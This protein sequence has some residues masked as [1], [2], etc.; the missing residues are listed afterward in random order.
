M[1]LPR[2]P[3]ALLVAVAAMTAAVSACA[4]PDAT[5]GTAIP[6]PGQPANQHLEFAEAQGSG[7]A[8]AIRDA[9]VVHRAV[10]GAWSAVPLP[11]GVGPHDVSDVRTTASGDLLLAS[12]DHA[13]GLSFYTTVHGAPGWNHTQL[14]PQWP[15]GLALSGPP[16]LRIADSQGQTVAVAAI[17][18]LSTA[19]GVS[20]LFISH[21]DGLSFS[22]I[23]FPKLNPLAVGWSSLALT[24]SGGLIVGG[25]A[26]N[27]AFL[28]TDSGSSWKPIP[29]TELPSGATET[30][31]GDAIPVG[32]NTLVPAF[33]DDAAGHQVLS[34]L[35]AAA[36]GLVTTPDAPA[37][38][39]STRYG[40]GGLPIASRG[41][42]VWVLSADSKRVFTLT[43]GTGWVATATAGLPLGVTGLSLTGP[44][45]ADASVEQTTCSNGK[46]DCTTVSAVY[47]TTDH[48][49]TWAQVSMP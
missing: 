13:G 49:S 11:T 18:Q 21:D 30:F 41:S 38:I 47:T 40:A 23:T 8:W 35:A 37:L 19:V 24:A 44:G 10:T 12:L 36:T 6:R 17:E 39:V 14:V 31:L 20:N 34:L 9:A 26:H 33:T 16:R 15:S 46:A 25:P 2:K 28:S 45:T 5:I 3:V 42:D 22:R 48:G 7:G 43:L 29:L 32:G 27:K 4:N 1:I